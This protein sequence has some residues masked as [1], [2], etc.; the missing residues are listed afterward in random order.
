MTNYGFST[1][2]KQLVAELLQSLDVLQ[3]TFEKITLKDFS[4]PE[5]VRP[6]LWVSSLVILIS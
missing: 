4:S 2:L 5:W 6:V 1:Y 3:E